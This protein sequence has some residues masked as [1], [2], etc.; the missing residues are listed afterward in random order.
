MSDNYEYEPVI[1]NGRWVIQAT[2]DDGDIVIL[3]CGDVDKSEIWKRIK[4]LRMDDD[5]IDG[6][7]GASRKYQ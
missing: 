3:T 2:D 5:H 4:A 6:G 1:H 7:R